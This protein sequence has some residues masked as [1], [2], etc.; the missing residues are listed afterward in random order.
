MKRP[1]DIL[2]SLC[3]AFIMPPDVIIYFVKKFF[4]RCAHLIITRTGNILH[5]L[6]HPLVD[7]LLVR[8]DTCWKK[9][10]Q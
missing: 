1:L 10:N 8:K 4:M 6:I 5:Q 2:L 7:Q 9:N 3:E